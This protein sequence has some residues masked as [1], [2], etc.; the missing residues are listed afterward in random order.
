MT[1]ST[2][3]RISNFSALWCWPIPLSDLLRDI[4][5]KSNI[6]QLHILNYGK[7][8]NSDGFLIKHYVY[9]LG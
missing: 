8:F 5:L 9:K 2:E 6:I 3:N 1:S 4:T 7:S